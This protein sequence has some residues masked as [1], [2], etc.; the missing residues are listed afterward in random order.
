MA[1]LGGV[2]NVRWAARSTAGTT[3][4]AMV[5]RPAS[6]STAGCGSRPHATA[7]TAKPQTKSERIGANYRCVRSVGRCGLLLVA[8]AAAGRGLVQ[9]DVPIERLQLHLRA[10]VAEGEVETLPLPLVGDAD[11]QRRLE[12]A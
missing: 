6:V 3:C 9:V 10:A 11:G 2:L 8:G 5:S 12:P 1:S 4:R 7:A